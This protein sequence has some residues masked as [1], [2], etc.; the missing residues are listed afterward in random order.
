VEETLYLKIPYTLSEMKHHY[1]PRVHLLADPYLQLGLADLCSPNCRQPQLHYW[2]QRLYHSL[3]HAAVNTCF[4]REL[5][6]SDTRMKAHHAEGTLR[7][8]VPDRNSK[9]VVLNLARAGAVPSFACY[10][11]LNRFFNPAGI[12]QDYIISSRSL[13]DQGEVQGSNIGGA[14]IGGSVEGAF[15]VV[16]DPMGATGGTLVAS[17]E[18][19]RKLGKPKGWIALHLIVTPEYLKKVLAEC[20]DLQVFALRLDRGLSDAKTLQ[21]AAGQSWN[22]EKGLNSH[23]YIVPGGGGFGEILNNTLE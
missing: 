3:L 15:V 7:V 14:K 22:S 6:V 5:L 18:R 9:A 23:Q 8:E 13:N 4:D 11:E 12:R 1:G 20:P 10:D 2:V 16:P 19:Y 17:Y 21:L